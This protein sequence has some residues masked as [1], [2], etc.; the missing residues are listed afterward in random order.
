MIILFL[1]LYIRVE[2]TDNL[3]IGPAKQYPPNMKVVRRTYRHD[4]V[5]HQVCLKRGKCITLEPV[6]LAS[7][8]LQPSEAENDSRKRHR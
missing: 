8:R 1:I 5:Q 2:R 3:E 7:L 6:E 4:L